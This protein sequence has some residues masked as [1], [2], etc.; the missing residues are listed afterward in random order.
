MGCQA[1]RCNKTPT[2]YGIFIVIPSL[3]GWPTK[4]KE[5]SHPY[6]VRLTLLDTNPVFH[7]LREDDNFKSCNTEW[8]KNVQKYVNIR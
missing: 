6:E 4:A 5:A 2:P 1:G 8:F 7:C 3:K